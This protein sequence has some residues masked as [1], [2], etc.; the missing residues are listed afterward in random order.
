M[1]IKQMIDIVRNSNKVLTYYTLLV[2][3]LDFTTP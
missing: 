2:C 1:F 3:D